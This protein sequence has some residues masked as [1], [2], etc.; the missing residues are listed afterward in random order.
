METIRIQDDLY[1]HVNQAKLAELVIPEDMPVMGSAMALMTGVEKLMIGKSNVMPIILTRFLAAEKL[2]GI[3]FA[4]A[5]ENMLHKPSPKL[6][7]SY[8]INACPDFGTSGAVNS[9]AITGS[10]R[11]DIIKSKQN[12]FIKKIQEHPG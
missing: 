10:I 2:I 6:S 3:Y 1:T 7:G 12:N 5:S 4:I 9:T 11:N 8:G